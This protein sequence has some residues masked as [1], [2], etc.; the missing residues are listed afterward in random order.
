MAKYDR[1]PLEY[2][3]KQGNEP[4]LR[5]FVVGFD[6]ALRVRS[7]RDGEADDEENADDDCCSSHNV[8]KINNSGEPAKQIPPKKFKALRQISPIS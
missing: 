2:A 4:L 8:A 6:Q 3:E 1:N 7:R 5:W